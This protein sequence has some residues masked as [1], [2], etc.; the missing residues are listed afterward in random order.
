LFIS[1][2]ARIL[3]QDTT[4][5]GFAFCKKTYLFRLDTKERIPRIVSDSSKLENKE[6]KVFSPCSGGG[7]AHCAQDV[8]WGIFLTTGCFFLISNP[9]V[10]F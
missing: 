6:K 1:K 9:S 5:K 8:L 4:T 3:L 2:K 7:W 10:F